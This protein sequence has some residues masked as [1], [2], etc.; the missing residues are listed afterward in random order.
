MVK[1]GMSRYLSLLNS[2]EYHFLEPIVSPYLGQKEIL[3]LIKVV[4][5][6]RG[7]C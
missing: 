4:K 1:Y 3:N 5:M 7:P 6:N 2:I